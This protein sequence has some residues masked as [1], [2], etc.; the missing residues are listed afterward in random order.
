MILDKE[1]IERKVLA[2]LNRPT[3]VNGVTVPTGPIAE[4]VGITITE[5]QHA[6]SNLLQRGYITG[7]G[8]ESVITPEGH[9]WLS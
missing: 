4:D 1:A 7:D 2:S 6:L 8:A 5:L 9:A 3:L